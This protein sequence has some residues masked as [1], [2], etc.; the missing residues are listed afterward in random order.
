MPLG[1]TR[2]ATTAAPITIAA[3]RQAWPD[4]PY[5]FRGPLGT[6][7]RERKCPTR[8]PLLETAA[9]AGAVLVWPCCRGALSMVAAPQGM[10]P[11]GGHQP[12]RLYLCIAPG[13]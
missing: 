10:E 2:L 11:A 13:L 6:Y 1:R 5:A 3:R 7:L 12:E 8:S 4:P 9:H